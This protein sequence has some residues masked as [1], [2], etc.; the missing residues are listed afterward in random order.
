MR[1]MKY[2]L[3]PGTSAWVQ[4]KPFYCQIQ[5]TLKSIFKI[6]WQ[7]KLSHLKPNLATFLLLFCDDSLCLRVSFCCFEGSLNNM[8]FSQRQRDSLCGWF[9]LWSIF[10]EMKLVPFFVIAQ[11]EP[12]SIS[13]MLIKS[14]HSLRISVLRRPIKI[15][16]IS[17]ETASVV[18]IGLIWN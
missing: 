18:T 4:W 2:P 3:H 10:T 16:S 9:P 5:F 17:R 6:V 12:I 13:K 11:N 15:Q 8:Q 14:C 7:D 1:V